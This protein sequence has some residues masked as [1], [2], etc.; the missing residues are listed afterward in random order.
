MHL[1]STVGPQLHNLRLLEMWRWPPVT[2]HPLRFCTRLATLE[3]TTLCPEKNYLLGKH[4]FACCLQ[5]LRQC[6]WP[7][8]P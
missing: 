3:V 7:A 2:F 5:A 1:L 6:L 8:Y 4:E